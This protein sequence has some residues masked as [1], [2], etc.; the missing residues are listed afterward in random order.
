MTSKYVE[1][2]TCSKCGSY[3]VTIDGKKCI[4]VKWGTV[5]GGEISKTKHLRSQYIELR[6]V[7]H[8]CLERVWHE[9]RDIKAI[10]QQAEDITQSIWEHLNKE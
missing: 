8:E 4:S 10:D 6:K 7:V 2:I 9:Y 5:C 1:H 3:A